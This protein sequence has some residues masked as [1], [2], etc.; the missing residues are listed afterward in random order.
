MSRRPPETRAR[1]AAVVLAVGLA[2]L[3]VAA[4]VLYRPGAPRWTHVVID[5]A[6]WM[7]IISTGTLLLASAA[8]KL[9][10]I[11]RRRPTH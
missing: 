7:L 11:A 1:D 4:A 2:V 3:T 8:E 6:A 10:E 9:V 5:G